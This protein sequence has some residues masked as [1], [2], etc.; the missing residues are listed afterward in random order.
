MF[1][2]QHFSSKALA[3]NIYQCVF[4]YVF[5]SIINVSRV[6]GVFLR[7]LDLNIIIIIIIFVSTIV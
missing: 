1:E 2:Q 5:N 4:V 7:I 6:F 3:T